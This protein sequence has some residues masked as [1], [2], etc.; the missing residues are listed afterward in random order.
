[1]Q[2]LPR[3][4]QRK[5]MNETLDRLVKEAQAGQVV[6]HVSL[7]STAIEAREARKGGVRPP[8]PET[9]IEKY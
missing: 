5:A 9:I 1:M 7:D 6:Y 2:S 4:W 8:K 3:A